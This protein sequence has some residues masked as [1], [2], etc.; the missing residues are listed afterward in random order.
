MYAYKYERPAVTVD[1]VLFSTK[2]QMPNVLLIQRKNDPFKGRWAIPGG[3]IEMD[4]TLKQSATRELKEETGVNISEEKLKQ[5]Y[6][7]GD[8]N[9]DPR[10]R[11]ITVVY[12]AIVDPDD[13]KLRAASDASDTKW[14][15]CDDLPQLAFDHQKILDMALERLNE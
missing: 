13:V 4:E 3:F 8:P 14:F 2:G 6:T 10:H 12:L 11:T 15:P 5:L 9:R 1:I 7:F